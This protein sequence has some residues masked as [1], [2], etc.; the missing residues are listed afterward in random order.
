[1]IQPAH[2]SVAAQADHPVLTPLAD[3]AAR[4]NLAP[5]ARRLLELRHWLA[6][7]LVAFEDGIVSVEAALGGGPAIDP[8]LRVRRAAD[9][10]LALPGKRI[11]PL[12]VLLAARMGGRA[13]DV[14]VRH[15]AIACE[16]VHAATLLHDDVIDDSQERRGAP[17]SR[18]LFGNSASILG[19]DYLLVQAL[20]L[21]Q[22]A[23]AGVLLPD[24]LAVMSRIVA[25]EALQLERRG[26][27]EPDRDIYLQVVRGKTAALFDWGLRAGATL[28]HLDAGARAALGDV[29]MHL[30][31]AFQLV[32]DIL[33][34]EG[35]PQVTGKE[36]LQDIRE[37]KLTWPMILASEANASLR[38][39]LMEIAQVGVMA[40]GQE[41]IAAVIHCVRATGALTASRAYACA[42]AQSACAHLGGLPPGRARDALA[43]IVQSAVQRMQ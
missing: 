29:G 6:D 27:F 22:G 21:V 2:A 42:E 23:D 26:R 17:A 8:G 3:V 43:L 7:D 14:H 31:L 39:E 1:M 4:E 34:I 35:D 15:T 16:L 28:A 24:L 18:V 11:R 12:C 41:R 33:D 38:A 10:L 25:A 5:L 37:G 9:H 36:A 40:Y 30:G 19:G 13:M 20:R 32:D